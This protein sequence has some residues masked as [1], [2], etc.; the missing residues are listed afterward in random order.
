MI[1]VVRGLPAAGGVFQARVWR[2]D[3]RMGTG[4]WRLG[5][6]LA[7]FDLFRWCSDRLGEGGSKCVVLCQV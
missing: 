2:I 3:R 6:Q 1:T 5:V 4:R 7:K